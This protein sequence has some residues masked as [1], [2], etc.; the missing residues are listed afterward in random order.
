MIKKIFQKFSSKEKGSYGEAIAEKYFASKGFEIVYKNYKTRLGEIDL[1]ARKKD[2]LVFVEI[3]SDFKGY[4]F[5]CEEKIDLKK[6][7]KIFKVAEEFL[8]KNSKLLS[9]IKEIRF[10]VVV[11]KEGRI[12]HYENAFTKDDY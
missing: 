9:K 2:L 12:F 5:I 3:K 11:V 8:V 1:I 10:D 6:R 4:D 7:E